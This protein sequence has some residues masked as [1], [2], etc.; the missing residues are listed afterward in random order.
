MDTYQVGQFPGKPQI[1]VTVPGSKSITNRAL[2]MAAMAEGMTTLRG[3]LFSDDSR[4]FVKALQELGFEVEVDEQEKNV[5]V[6]GMGGRIPKKQAEIYVGSAGTAARFLTAF[7]AMSDGVYCLESSEQMRKRPMRELIEALRQLGADIQCLEEEDTFPME[8]TG[9]GFAR[10]HEQR[11]PKKKPLSL[12][13]H[14]L[15]AP[16]EICL[17]IDRS[18]QFLSALLMTAPLQFQS[19]TIH[20]TGTRSA[21]SYVEMTEQMMKQFEHPGVVR[22]AQDSYQ[23]RGAEYV[24]QEY[25]IEPDVSA[26]C[27][28]Y[29]AAAITGGTAHVRHVRKDSL[30]GD[31]KFLQVL[32]QMGCK[33]HWRQEQLCLT[34]P[35]PGS[36]HGV[37]VDLG[38]F[39]DQTLTLAAIAPFADSPVTIRHVG[40]IRGQECDRI[41]A[42]CINMERMKVRC[43]EKE[44]GVVIYPSAPQPAVIATYED[45]RVAMAFAVT[46]LVAPGIEIEN[47]SC[48]RK[49]FENYFEVL[50]QVL[51]ENSK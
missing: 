36:L 25:Q 26:A 2:L 35:E 6:Q 44:D 23:V 18:S 48:C 7:V 42:I 49:T 47:P 34:G 17:D 24:A 19:L 43:Q 33:L 29:A 21:R 41:H 14:T 1:T 51:E 46:G 38:D 45:H 37:D 32:Q 15:F 11:K 3:V 39:S 9:V 12:G 30:Q 28:F 8:I 10:E 27:Y 4:V 50:N 31:M 40:H 13:E 5:R 20:L 16:E 22:L